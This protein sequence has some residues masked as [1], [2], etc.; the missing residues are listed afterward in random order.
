LAG[1]ACELKPK[2]L[3]GEE[4]QLLIWEYM[5]SLES[6]NTDFDEIRAGCVMLMRCEGF[7]WK[8]FDLELEKRMAP[9]YQDAYPCTIRSLP[10]V[11]PSTFISVCLKLCRLFLKKELAERIVLCTTEQLYTQH[12]YDRGEAIHTVSINRLSLSDRPSR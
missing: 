2:S 11:N 8:N 10:I 12:G 4:Q 3:N 5:L 6:M 1:S 7:G 9:L